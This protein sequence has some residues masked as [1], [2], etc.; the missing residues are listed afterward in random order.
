[1]AEFEAEEAGLMEVRQA[2][3]TETV[4]TTFVI[5]AVTVA[6]AVAVGLVLAWFIGNGIARPIGKMTAVMGRLAQGDTS[7]DVEGA[8][9]L[10]EVGEMAGA[11]QVFKE[12]AVEA[13]R[14]VEERIEQERKAEED[15]RQA[16]LDL[17]DSLEQGVKGVV[18]AVSSGAS[19]MQSAAESM[20]STSEETS[21]QSQAAAAS[22]QAS[23]NVQTV[24]AAAE[25]M[26]SSI[27]EIARQV[28]QAIMAKDAV[29]DA[30]KTNQSVQ[31]LPESSQ[32]IGEV[33]E[34]ISDIASQTNLLAPNA[35]IEVARAGNAGKGFAIVASEVK[36]LATQTAKATEEIAAQ[37]GAIQGATE[38]SVTAIASAIEE[39][40]AATG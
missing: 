30:E 18:D 22:E 21:R 12:K 32:E 34:I 3:N 17:A 28:A 15:K 4:S 2:S 20:S 26:S 24:S 33:V 36:S 19:E 23:T 1:M 25:E 5:I 37:F 6:A 9:R 14:L 35:T 27:N 16:L 10:D 31:G 39:Q 40:G 8:E 7:V 13:E 11:V 38:G 29:D